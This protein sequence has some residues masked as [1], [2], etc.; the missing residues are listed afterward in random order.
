MYY[1]YCITNL[2]NNKTYIGQHKT[3][4][5]ND[6]YMGSGTLLHKAYKKYGIENFEKIILAVT[7]TRENV[8]I[9]EKVFIK[10]FREEGKAE[11]NITD[12]GDGV[13]CSGVREIERR[14]KI[15]KA[16]KN[17]IVSEETR[18]KLSESNKGKGHPQKEETKIKIAE[19]VSE[20]W[21]NL[22]YKNKVSK[23]IGESRKGIKNKNPAWNK[24]KSTN[25]HWY[26]NGK[27]NILCKECPEGFVKG[28]IISEEI[29]Q[30]LRTINIGKSHIVSEETRKKISESQKKNPNR[31]M[32][33][34]HHTEETK[35]KM[36]ES[37]KNKI[38][39]QETKKKLSNYM[40]GRKM[41][42]INGKRTWIKVN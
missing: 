27:D 22:E 12:G 41:I 42:S 5:L 6:N 40:K 23:K 9:L 7:E 38:V 15:S 24:N 14:I 39:S 34:K 31:A 19:S 20:R 1:I 13:H 35:K 10:L 18:K 37:A 36:S 28:R 33:G 3:N 25:C 30:N 8:D 32:L 17:R 29:K 2:V 26:N 16:G 11:Y 21:K 4:N